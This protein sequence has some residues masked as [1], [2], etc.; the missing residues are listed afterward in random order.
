MTAILRCALLL[1]ACLLV[2]LGGRLPEGC[3]SGVA[4]RTDTSSP[5]GTA[6]RIRAATGFVEGPTLSPDEKSL[7]YHKREG[8]LFVIYEVTRP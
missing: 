3:R 8:S 6:K 2:G 5:F 1:L 7:Y 4:V